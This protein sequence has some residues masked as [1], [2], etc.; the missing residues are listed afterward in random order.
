MN[1]L[2]VGSLVFLM[3]FSCILC[4]SDGASAENKESLLGTADGMPSVVQPASGYQSAW[5]GIPG[6]VSMADIVRMG[7]PHNKASNAPNASN[8]N[9]QDPSTTESL[10]NLRFP[11]DHAPKVHQS[12]VSS[13]QHVPTTDEW[14]SIEKP[15]PADVISVPEYTVD[16]ELHPEASDVPFDNINHHSEAEEV[17]EREDDNI[18]SS[19]GNDLGSVSI[20]SRKIP[21]NDLRSA[22]LFENELY[23]S[24]GSYQSEATDFERHQ[25]DFFR[26]SLLTR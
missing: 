8:H 26:I 15:A 3:I 24:M 12:E 11:A 2:L 20:S 13:V 21:E 18:E 16:S 10:H 1:F 5:A 19:E 25:G 17:R 14:P 4:C 22:S 9:V 23:K 7:R 6:H